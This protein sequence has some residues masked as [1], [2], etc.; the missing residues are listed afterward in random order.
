MRAL[1][2]FLLGAAIASGCASIELPGYQ[3][4]S[5]KPYLWQGIAFYEE[6]NYRAA[7]R[8]LHFALEEGLSV[9]DRVVAHKYLAFIACVSGQQLTCR[10]EFA[11]AL[12][13]DRKFELDEA[14]AGHPIW[15]PVFRSARDANVGK[16]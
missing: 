14:E 5:G 10:E 3:R 9:A 2:L 1:L 11:I 7:S 12:K 16:R 8:R 6:G 4:L 15:G 13:L